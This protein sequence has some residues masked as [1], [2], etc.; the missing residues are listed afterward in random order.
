MWNY[1]SQKCHK[2][3][4]WWV[5]LRKFPLWEIVGSLWK[6]EEIRLEVDKCFCCLLNLVWWNWRNQMGLDTLCFAGL[7]TDICL[8]E[9][10]Y[11]IKWQSG[12]LHSYI[13]IPDSINSLCQR[14]STWRGSWWS[15]VNTIHNRAGP[16]DRIQ[17][18]KK[19][20]IIRPKVLFCT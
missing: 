4:E 7:D 19:Q 13:S 9:Q 6:E 18:T 10:R 12:V 14:T 5:C 15:L 11:Q 2:F 16:V 20:K 1:N 17:T 8:P 3:F